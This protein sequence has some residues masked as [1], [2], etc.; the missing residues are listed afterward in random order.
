MDQRRNTLSPSPLRLAGNALLSEV[1]R[2]APVPATSLGTRG[3]S[4][5]AVITLFAL[6]LN[7]SSL[8]VIYM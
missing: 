5:N 7:V 2:V 3:D 8:N 1:P 6:L 4:A